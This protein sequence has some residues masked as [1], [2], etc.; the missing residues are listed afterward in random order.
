MGV[1][2]I[3]YGVRVQRGTLYMICGQV[4]D[5]KSCSPCRTVRRDVHGKAPRWGLAMGLPRRP[6][7]LLLFEHFFLEDSQSR[8][9]SLKPLSLRKF[10]KDV[11]CNIFRSE[12][13][14]VN[15]A[16]TFEKFI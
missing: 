5:R 16:E 1:L 3:S 6:K 10:Q 15:G 12:A 13:Y 7:R 9:S 2:Q 8:S 11:T 4:T 14:D